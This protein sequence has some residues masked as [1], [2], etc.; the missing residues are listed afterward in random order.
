MRLNVIKILKSCSNE[1]KANFSNVLV[2]VKRWVK[3]LKSTSDDAA[4]Q[5]YIAWKFGTHMEFG[6]HQEP[7]QDMD[8][9]G[10][11][12]L[13]WGYQRDRLRAE[14]KQKFPTTSINSNYSITTVS[15]P[16]IV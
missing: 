6:Q 1:V 10:D 13:Q 9:I 2:E 7:I 5:K 12:N 16:A 4:F 11:R 8:D 14:V 3:G 15:T